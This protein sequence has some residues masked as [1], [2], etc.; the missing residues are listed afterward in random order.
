[1]LFERR[2]LKLLTLIRL[3]LAVYLLKYQR[4]VLNAIMRYDV[5]TFNYTHF[6]LES[7]LLNI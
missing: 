5:T 7:Q 2:I 6:L 3:T 4:I 1:M